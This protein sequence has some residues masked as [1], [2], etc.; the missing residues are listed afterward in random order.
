MRVIAFIEDDAVIR[1]ILIHLGLWDT[2]NHDPP[3][4]APESFQDC[5]IDESYS[6]LP[7]TDYWMI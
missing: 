5:I 2:R 3:H 7:Q 6:Q 4:P 1:K